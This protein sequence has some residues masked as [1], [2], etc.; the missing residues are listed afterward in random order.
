MLARN[1]RGHRMAIAALE[2]GVWALEASRQGQS[3]AKL[4]V[5]ASELSRGSAVQPRTQVDTGIALG[6]KASSAELASRA[7]QA[8][9]EGYRRIKIKIEPGRDVREL[10]AVRE[11]LGPGVPITADANCS[12]SLDDPAHVRAL[13]TMDGLGLAMIEQPLGYEDLECHARLQRRLRTPIC[14]DESITSRARA[15]EMLA[16]GSARILNLKPGRVGG[17]TEAVAIH[18]RCARAGVPVWCGGMLESGVGRAYN[19]ALASLPNF[20]EPGDL[21]PSARY[22]ERDIVLPAW[23]MDDAGRVTVPL[24]RP[25]IGVDI[26]VA[27]VDDLTTRVV[28]LSSP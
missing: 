17:L 13:D 19:V 15:E 14:L 9:A 4:L 11:A 7:A 1:I 24:Q 10:H 3:L 2:M 25:G 20:T 28:T 18:D 16:L 22:W 12:Y 21:S 27:R 6:I 5:D 8:L 23:T 26:D